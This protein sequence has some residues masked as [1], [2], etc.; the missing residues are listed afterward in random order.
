MRMKEEMK[1]LL[2]IW[3]DID[4]NYRIEFEKWHNCEHMADRV[5]IPGFN[6]GYR[7]QGIGDA[8]YSL[9]IYETL[10]ST[11]LESEPYL[12]SKNNPTPWAREALSHFRNTLRMI[13]S[14]L[15]TVGK[16]PPTQAPYI[17]VVRFNS[18]PGGEK[19]AIGWWKEDFLPKIITLPGVHRGRLWEVNAEISN[20]PTEEQ[21]IYGRAKIEQ[22]R[23]LALIEMVSMDLPESKVWQDIYMGSGHHSR[24]LQRMTNVSEELYWLRFVMSAPESN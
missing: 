12:H 13:Y 20:I 16:K 24:S 21:K 11:V 7:Y 19:E 6:I 3:A 5:T 1:G 18:E 17:F 4:E 15:A 8:P 2:A 10:D 14:L 23:H 9:M 22:Q